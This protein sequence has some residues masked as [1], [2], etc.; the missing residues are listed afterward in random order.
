MLRIIL[1]VIEMDIFN[2]MPHFRYSSE[3]ILQISFKIVT[4][5]RTLLY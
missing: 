3:I 2:V 1:N 4:V 5:L